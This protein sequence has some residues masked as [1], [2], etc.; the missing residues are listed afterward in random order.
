MRDER[1]HYQLM[2]RRLRIE[3]GHS[4][5]D[6][7][8]K[9]DILVLIQ[10][11]FYVQIWLYSISRSKILLSYSTL[12]CCQMGGTMLDPESRGVNWLSLF[13]MEMLR[14]FTSGT[15][16]SMATNLLNC[17]FLTLLLLFFNFL[18]KLYFPP[19][20]Y[21]LRKNFKHFS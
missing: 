16:R 8:L 14:R 9:M 7:L 6:S 21:I 4:M 17:V 13:L 5:A 18:S 1:L 3:Q 15:V 10:R 20:L 2:S 11:N 19:K 12:T